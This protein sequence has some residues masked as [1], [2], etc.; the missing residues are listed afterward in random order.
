M[1]NLSEV[2]KY[3]K[4]LSQLLEKVSEVIKNAES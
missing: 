1:N 4:R 3:E 2:D